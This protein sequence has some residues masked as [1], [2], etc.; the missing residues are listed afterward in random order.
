[1]ETTLFEIELIDGRIFRIFCGNSSQ[2]RRFMASSYKIK[3]LVK[4]TKEI[5]NG[6]H[7]VNEWE[8]IAF[9]VD[10]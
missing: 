10:W 3:H 2:K 5:T 9:K 6:I 1:M 4:S 7:T 8:K